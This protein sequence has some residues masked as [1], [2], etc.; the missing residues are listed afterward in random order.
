VADPDDW[1]A[2]TIAPFLHAW[3]EALQVWDWQG[4]TRLDLNLRAFDLRYNV[5]WQNAVIPPWRLVSE[6]HDDGRPEPA[7]WIEAKLAI[8]LHQHRPH[9]LAI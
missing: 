9:G 1:R 2:T 3:V 6:W 8:M 5:D 4:R 7:A